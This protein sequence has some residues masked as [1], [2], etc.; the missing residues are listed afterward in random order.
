MVVLVSEMNWESDE[1]WYY[2]EDSTLIE[3]AAVSIVFS[4]LHCNS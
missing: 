1:Q 3:A 2:E 4:L